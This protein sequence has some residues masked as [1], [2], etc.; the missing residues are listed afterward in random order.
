MTGALSGRQ[1]WYQNGRGLSLC[2]HAEFISVSAFC[3]VNDEILKQV[4]DDGGG[5]R[6]TGALSG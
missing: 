3:F 5:I 4:Q 6:M 2:R 1:R